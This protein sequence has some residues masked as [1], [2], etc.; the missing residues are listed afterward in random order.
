MNKF[1]QGLRKLLS[2][3]LDNWIINYQPSFDGC[4]NIKSKI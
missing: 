4:F 2:K 3:S 1:A